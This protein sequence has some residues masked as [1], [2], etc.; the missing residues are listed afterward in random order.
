LLQLSFSYFF[1]SG[2]WQIIKTESEEDESSAE[3]NGTIALRP[4]KKMQVWRKK[5]RK[6]ERPIT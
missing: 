2:K 4:G 5:E 3:K 1:Q 6:K